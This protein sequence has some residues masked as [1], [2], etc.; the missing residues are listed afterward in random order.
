MPPLSVCPVILDFSM[1]QIPLRYTSNKEEAIKEK[2][3]QVYDLAVTLAVL[4]QFY[5]L[6]NASLGYDDNFIKK[7][8]KSFKIKH[9]TTI[10]LKILY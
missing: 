6:M 5:N 10:I 2:L 4:A 8:K 9:S 1:L 3:F 7:F